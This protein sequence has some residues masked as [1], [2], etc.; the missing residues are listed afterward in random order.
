MRHGTNFRFD[1]YHTEE[2][3]GRVDHGHGL[4]ASNAIYASAREDLAC[5]SVIKNFISGV[6]PQPFNANIDK[7]KQFAWRVL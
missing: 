5:L 4:D 6:G 2:V 1:T 7:S 3:L